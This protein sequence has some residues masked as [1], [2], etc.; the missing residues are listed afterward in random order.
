M[1]YEVFLKGAM[2]IP[3]KG[4][5]IVISYVVSHRAKGRVISPANN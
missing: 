5:M 1:L 4:L 3:M 2:I